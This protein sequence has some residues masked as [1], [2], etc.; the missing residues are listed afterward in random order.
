MPMLD[1]MLAET[2]IERSTIGRLAV[3]HGP[4]TRRAWRQRGLALACPAGQN[5]WHFGSY[6]R[7]HELRTTRFWSRSIPSAMSLCP[8][9]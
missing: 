1:D 5:L 2:G 8:G 9:L 4:G 3:T 6:G 7:R